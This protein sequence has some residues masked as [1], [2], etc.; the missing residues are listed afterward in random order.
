MLIQGPEHGDLVIA[1]DHIGVGAVPREA[2]GADPKHAVVD[3][4]AE[5][6]RV[7]VGRR[8]RL[9]GGEEPFEIAVDVAHHEDGTIER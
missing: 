4:I 5:E 6:D 9:E 7:P 2:Q 8:I 3:E 1:E